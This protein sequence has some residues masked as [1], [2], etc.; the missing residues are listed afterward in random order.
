MDV[1][2][3][4]GA[5]LHHVFTGEKE[6]KQGEHHYAEKDDNSEPPRSTGTRWRIYW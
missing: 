6:A 1:H 3:A 5:S 4:H 2:E